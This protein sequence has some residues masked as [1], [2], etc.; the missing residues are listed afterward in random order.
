[1]FADLQSR[2]QG[3]VRAGALRRHALSQRFISAE[4]C[5]NVTVAPAHRTTHNDMALDPVDGRFLL[6]GGGD[7]HVTLF[8]TDGGGSSNTNAHRRHQ[9]R[10]IRPT[11]PRAQWIGPVHDYAVT[12]VA[13]HAFD[14]G[15]FVSGGNDGI[16]KA[17]DTNRLAVAQEFELKG[18]VTQCSVS[19]CAVAHALIA[20]TTE[21]QHVQL[22]DMASGG[23]VRIVV[24]PSSFCTFSFLHTRNAH[25]Y[26]PK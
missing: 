12:S 18:R 25:T 9:R 16:V 26:S 17:W 14:T 23:T 5:R 6:T 8:D 19:P 11:T 1:M 22:L 13:W 21:S 7:G 24:L 2:E 10:V 20:T 3:S 4:L 15:L